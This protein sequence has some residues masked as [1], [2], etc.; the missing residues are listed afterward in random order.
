MSFCENDMM[1]QSRVSSGINS[2]CYAI[3]IGTHLA[4]VSSWQ[5]IYTF[6]NYKIMQEI[7]IERFSV[8]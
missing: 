7:F 1:L 3:E 5:L 6:Q 8:G 4:V 2:Y